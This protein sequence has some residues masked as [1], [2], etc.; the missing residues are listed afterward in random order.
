LALLFPYSSIFWMMIPALSFSPALSS[1]I[2]LLLLS[3]P[4]IVANPEAALY[5]EI[6]RS[7]SEG[8]LVGIIAW[9]EKKQS[10]RITN[11]DL[12]DP[13]AFYK[14]EQEPDDFR[15]IRR[16]MV[17]QDNM[18]HLV[19]LQGAI[20]DLIQSQA[21]N[22]VD[23]QQK[24][25]KME[26]NI[27]AKFDHNIQTQKPHSHS[28]YLN[29]ETLTEYLPKIPK[30]AHMNPNYGPRPYKRST[31]KVSPYEARYHTNKKEAYPMRLPRYANPP[32]IKNRYPMPKNPSYDHS[33]ARNM[34]QL[35]QKE[36]FEVPQDYVVYH[37][38]KRNANRE[39]FKKS[40]ADYYSNWIMNNLG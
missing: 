19:G 21:Q 40:P 22:H 8:N 24:I 7:L 32:L 29:P 1:T 10:T 5:P 36:Y 25:P 3:P 11:L 6:P 28:S 4:L 9:P 20:T 14:G 15:T 33:L 2:C 16:M 18:D 12:K 26:D 35:P 27:N 17:S 37:Y 30:A 34:Y 23:I 39:M 31:L 13:G 38:K